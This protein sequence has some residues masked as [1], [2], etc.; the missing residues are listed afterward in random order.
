MPSGVALADSGEL[1]ILGGTQTQVGDFPTVVAV[2]VN[3][4][5][6]LCTGT[7]IHPEWVL[8]AAHCISPAVI[9]GT[10]GAI[11]AA[12]RVR[13]DGMTAFQIGSGRTIG[14]LE[15]IPHPGFSINNLGDNDI[16]VIRLAEP[17]EDR[18][19]T[20]V[21]R[22]HD[23]APVGVT[24]TFVGYGMTQAGNPQSAGRQY[25][26]AN[27]TSIS[28]NLI[29]GDDDLILCF[30]Q[31]DGRGQCEGDSGG[32]TFTDVNGVQTIVGITSFGDQNC[33]LFGADTRVDAEISFADDRIGPSLACVWDGECNMNCGAENRDQDCPAC[34]EDDDC[35]GD[36]VCAA[37]GNCVP[38]PF[39]DGGLGSAC[40]MDEDCLTGPCL[41]NGDQHLCSSDCA[42]EDDCPDD[43]DC[44]P[45]EGGGGACWPTPGG[46]GGGGCSTTGDDLNPG[47]MVAVFAMLGFVVIGRRR[48]RS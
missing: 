15:T 26:L 7:L 9:G 21:N 28:C 32:P 2:E 43:F 31:Q 18:M 48:R 25:S 20:R 14:A 42:S 38:A 10:Q 37:N 13:I 45:L 47:V 12:T 33:S 16:G 29:G 19:V 44:L 17:V 40:V 11:T 22:N 30:N 46:G 35:E 24:V 6:A 41:A 8:T 3:P 36:D 39:T 34:A 27:R 1:P 5:G 23:D 4:P